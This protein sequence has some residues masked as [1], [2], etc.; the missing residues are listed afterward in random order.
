MRT[1]FLMMMLVVMSLV[2]CSPAP[3]PP[4][5][6]EVPEVEAGAGDSIRTKTGETFTVALESNPT[7]GYGWA[8][9]GKED[10]TVVRKVSDEFV[11]KPHP[12]GMVGVGGTERWTFQAAKPGKTALRFIYRRPWEKDVAPVRE[13]TVQVLVE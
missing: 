13:R 10:A 8:L 11:G 4:V 6:D 2:A 1:P 7:T 9:D 12:P 3:K 5:T